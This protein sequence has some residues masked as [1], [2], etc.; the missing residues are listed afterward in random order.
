MTRAKE[1]KKKKKK[2]KRVRR[3]HAEAL[4]PRFQPCL[5]EIITRSNF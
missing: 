4:S 3:W 2:K 5:T 1:E